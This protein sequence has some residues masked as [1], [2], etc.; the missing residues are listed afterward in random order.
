LLLDGYVLDWWGIRLESERTLFALSLILL[1]SIPVFSQSYHSNSIVSSVSSSKVDGSKQCESYPTHEPITVNDD[2]DFLLQGFTGNGTKDEPYLIDE[3]RF[4]FE[5]GYYDSEGI[6]IRNTRAFFVISHCIFETISGL[7]YSNSKSI[8]L[9]NAT[10]GLILN[11]T[12]AGVSSP[13]FWQC[14]NTT[15][16]NCSMHDCGRGILIGYSSHF[17]IT[18]NSIIRCSEGIDLWN[19]NS[20][21]ISDNLFLINIELGVQIEYPSCNNT[22]YHNR[23]GWNGLQVDGDN[24]VDNGIFNSWDDGI[25]TGNNWSDYNGAGTYSIPGSAGSID[26]Y[27]SIFIGDYLGPNITVL[28]HVE[29]T[30]D[31][32]IPWA[33]VLLVVL[34]N[35]PSGTDS[36]LVMT[37]S[38]SLQMVHEPTSEYPDRYVYRMEG[39]FDY[40]SL[41]Y[42]FWANDTLGHESKTGQFGFNF[43]IMN[44]CPGS[45]IAS[46]FLLVGVIGTAIAT[47]LIAFI[48]KSKEVSA[49]RIE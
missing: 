44:N 42:Y 27:P 41:Y 25:S 36:V 24:A 22:I 32:C 34:V 13:Y 14:Q 4:I 46:T 15:L 5:G 21:V 1:L 7:D 37:Y 2:G 28:S 20:S 31:G 6:G 49:S 45:S 12:F 38:S 18:N 39:P 35:D 19:V 16:A 3:F 48:K 9:S 8:S 47:T 17:E 33:E 30:I 10:N 23:I 29:G 43:G 40:I 26:R 11:C